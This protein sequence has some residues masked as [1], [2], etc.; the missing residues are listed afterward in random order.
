MVSIEPQRFGIAPVRPVYRLRCPMAFDGRGAWWLQADRETR[1]PYFGAAMPE[2]GDVVETISA[3][4][5]DAGGGR[6]HE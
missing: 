5:P 3:E 1:N 2:C 6:G 4:A